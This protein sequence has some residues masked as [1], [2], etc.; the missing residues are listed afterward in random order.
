M[1]S[2]TV[3][4][5]ELEP[6]IVVSRDFDIVVNAMER[7]L[8]RAYNYDLL[9]PALWSLIGFNWN[10]VSNADSPITPWLRQYIEVSRSLQETYKDSSQWP[11]FKQAF[12]LKFNLSEKELNEKTEVY[13]R[14]F[15]QLVAKNEVPNSI[16]R[17]WTYVPTK[18]NVATETG[19]VIASTLKPI[20]P[21]LLIGIAVY[22]GVNVLGRRIL[23]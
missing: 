22:A 16:L 23:P 21:Y 17:P 18:T 6:G 11:K 15:R 14:F 19:E 2:F 12:K 5:N 8:K 7:D 9:N 20:F 1:Y 3:G 10:L 13:M 4:A